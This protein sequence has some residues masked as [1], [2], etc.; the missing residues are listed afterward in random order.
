MKVK[1]NFSLELRNK[2]HH[3]PWLFNSKCMVL[4]STP[5]Y[6]NKVDSNSFLEGTSKNSN[7]GT[8]HAKAEMQL[9]NIK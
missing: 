9:K 3:G 8:Y 5:I 1:L 6:N 7:L 2:T 4:V